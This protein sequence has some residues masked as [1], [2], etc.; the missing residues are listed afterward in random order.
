MEK[1]KLK[2]ERALQ[3]LSKLRKSGIER[4]R[5]E[6][7]YFD[8]RNTIAALHWS[9]SNYRAAL[10]IWSENLKYYKRTDN[11]KGLLMTYSNIGNIYWAYGKYRSAERYYSD[12]LM[13]AKQIKE[14]RLCGVIMNN[15]GILYH[16]QGK[17]KQSVQAYK[18]YLKLCR[19]I[20]D[21]YGLALTLGNLGIV[22]KD[23]GE[24]DRAEET[25]SIQLKVSRELGHKQG[26]SVAYGNL[27]NVYRLRGKQKKAELTFLRG[28]DISKE[29]NYLRGTGIAYLNLGGLYAE[30]GKIKKT[31]SMF[32]SAQKIFIRIKD[33]FFITEILI[34]FSQLRLKQYQ[35]INKRK[36]NG[37]HN[38]PDRVLYEAG[39]FA[40][41]SLKKARRLNSRQLIASSLA[42]LGETSFYSKDFKKGEE[43]IQEAIEIFFKLKSYQAL[44]DLYCKIGKIYRTHKKESEAK[45]YYKLAERFY[46]KLKLK[47]PQRILYD[48]TMIG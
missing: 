6:F 14:I 5:V 48:D 35:L 7:L 46:G 1:D 36:I 2:G 45:R 39:K 26:V 20:D 24:Y 9:R 19:T 34:G 30:T 25:Y 8:T 18:K 29:V 22:Y 10:K 31:E 32:F 11:R 47:K 3:I 37:R 15:L 28:L 44:A 16:D 4:E 23:L 38:K 27:G 21:R 43:F 12:A 40:S 41:D 42:C 17:L 33:R 13:I